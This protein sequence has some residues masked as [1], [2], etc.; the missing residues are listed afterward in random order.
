MFIPFLET[1]LG[2]ILIIFGLFSFSFVFII[3]I[4]PFLLRTI[5]VNF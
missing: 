1:K 2:F 4:I 5:G 3:Y